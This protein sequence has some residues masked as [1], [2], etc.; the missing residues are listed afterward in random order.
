[1]QYFK[2]CSSILILLFLLSCNT[3]ID[4]KNRII[5]TGFPKE[6]Q[7]TGTAIEI[8]NSPENM[9]S[10]DS[11]VFVYNS[12][13]QKIFSVYDKN[14]FSLISEFGSIGRGPNEIKSFLTYG[15]FDNSD[16]CNLW[17]YDVNMRFMCLLDLARSIKNKSIIINKKISHT[18]KTISVDNIFCFSDS[19]TFGT[20]D[21]GKG[22]LFRYNNYTDEISWVPYS[23]LIKPDDISLFGNL[24][25]TYS[26]ISPDKKIIASAFLFFNRVDLFN[27]ESKD[28]LS[29]LFEPMGKEPLPPDKKWSWLDHNQQY[30]LDIFTTNDYIFLLR[31]NC[32]EK[33]MYDGNFKPVIEVIS[34]KGEAICRFHLDLP[35][36][37]ILVD[38]KDHRIIGGNFMTDGPGIIVYKF[39]RL[40][41]H[42]N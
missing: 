15:Q 25:K 10:F 30:F 13:K 39:N 37:R 5:I 42:E 8:N 23:P 7:L 41:P 40:N 22:Q 9:V 20:S 14:D 3:N 33:D 6:E 34:W 12:K 28:R 1:M 32:L 35:V 26:S 31:C 24:Y 21:N 18:Y 27:T 38:L 17:F 29:I 11:L 16:S 36:D 4:Q 2:L 19:V